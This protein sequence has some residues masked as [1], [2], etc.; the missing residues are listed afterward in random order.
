MPNARHRN[1]SH[2]QIRPVSITT[3]LSREYAFQRPARR[4]ACGE[5]ETNPRNSAAKQ[6]CGWINTSLQNVTAREN[7]A[8]RRKLATHGLK[9][10]MTFETQALAPSKSRPIHRVTSRQ[11]MRRSKKRHLQPRP[12]ATHVAKAHQYKV[13]N[14]D[15]P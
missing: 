15:S 10:T 6:P 7:V 2:R 1:E 3:R 13:V 14:P 5:K 11:V 12:V 4:L 8:S 9:S